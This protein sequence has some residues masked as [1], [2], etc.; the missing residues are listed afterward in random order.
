M[1]GRSAPALGALRERVE[2]KQTTQ[3]IDGAGGHVDSFT[4]LGVV[5]AKVTTASGSIVFSG[6]ARNAKITHTIIIRFRSDLKPGDR[7]NYRGEELEVVSAE[8]LNGRHAYLKVLC[9]QLK[10]V[11]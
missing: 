11:G 8:D 9:A 5:W 6:D 3:N 10:I 1:S 7:I 4:S 2:L